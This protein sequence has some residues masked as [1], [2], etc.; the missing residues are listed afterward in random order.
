MGKGNLGYKRILPPKKN[1]EFTEKAL[2][3]GV[4]L[5]KRGYQRLLAHASRTSGRQAMI[6]TDQ[7]GVLYE[8]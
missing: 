7:K 8:N 5:D 4:R 3:F 1:T 2:K 6:E